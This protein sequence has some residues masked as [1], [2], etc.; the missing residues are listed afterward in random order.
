MSSGNWNSRRFLSACFLNPSQSRSYKTST[1]GQIYY[2]LPNGNQVSVCVCVCVEGSTELK[3][4]YLKTR[5]KEK[6]SSINQK[7]PAEEASSSGGGGLVGHVGR[8]R[9]KGRRD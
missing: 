6:S 7:P 9:A 5:E 2:A 8:A 1:C 4:T 3:H